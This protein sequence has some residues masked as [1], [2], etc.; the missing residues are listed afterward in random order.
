MCND[1]ATEIGH[2][3]DGPWGCRYAQE[4]LLESAVNYVN[5]SGIYCGLSPQISFTQTD[6]KILH[7]LGGWECVL[8]FSIMSS[9]K[10]EFG[11]L[12]L[13]Q[14]GKHN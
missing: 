13:E 12:C 7:F 3:G 10:R 4:E 8:L 6:F 2:R 11:K 1:R 14:V 5:Y 9:L